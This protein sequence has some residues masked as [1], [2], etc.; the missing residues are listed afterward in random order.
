[1]LRLTCTV[2]QPSSHPPAPSSP[3][4][5]TVQDS[6]GTQHCVVSSYTDSARQR[7]NA[8]LCRPWRRALA[9]DARG[10]RQVACSELAAEDPRALQVGREP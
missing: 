1:M 3:P 9:A 5:R 6:A 10:P 8:A 4:T 2:P 7:W